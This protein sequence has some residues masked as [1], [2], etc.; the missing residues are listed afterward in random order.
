VSLKYAFIRIV[1]AEYLKIWAFRIPT[2]GTACLAFYMILVTYDLFGAEHLSAHLHIVS[3]FTAVPYIGFASWAKLIVIPLF[4][5]ALGTYCTLVDSQYGMVRIG[6]SQPV[7][8][9]T[10]V[11][12]KT[13]AI[14]VHAAS[15]VLLYAVFLLA[16]SAIAGEQWRMTRADLASFCSFTFRLLILNIGI[17]WLV[18][19]AAL[20]RRTL[21]AGLLTAMLVVIAAVWLNV[22]PVE[23]GLRPYL[24]FRYF[25][26]PFAP[27]W[28]SG[29]ASV[30]EIP[31]AGCTSWQFAVAALGIPAAFWAVAVSYFSNRDITE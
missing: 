18:V 15:F 3:A 24:L 22:L 31:N 1:R 16:A 26:Y 14:I 29:L 5:I 8:R 12:A 21:L 6:C 7:R 2:Y 19:A 25:L 23:Y 13:L 10:Y 4:L 9:T 27:I 28:P 20:F 30:I 17:V 11:G